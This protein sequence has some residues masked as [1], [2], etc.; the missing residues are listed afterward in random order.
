MKFEKEKE[1]WYHYI[2]VNMFWFQLIFCHFL[3]FTFFLIYLKGFSLKSVQLIFAVLLHNVYVHFSSILFSVLFL[4]FII[5]FALLSPTLQYI[6]FIWE[7]H[8]WHFITKIHGR[9]KNV[10]LSR[11]ALLLWFSL[12]KYWWYFIPL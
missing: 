6:V 12:N 1:K 10:N 9:E 3:D 8:L 5:K 4:A 11:E 7:F 2:I